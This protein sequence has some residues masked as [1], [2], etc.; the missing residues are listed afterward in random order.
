MKGIIKNKEVQLHQFK[1]KIQANR[2]QEIRQSNSLYKT[3]QGFEW[4][5]KEECNGTII[6]IG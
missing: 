2:V 5:E 6:F 4:E 1:D 3:I